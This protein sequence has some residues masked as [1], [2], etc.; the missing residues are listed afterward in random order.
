MSPGGF[1]PFVKS[2]FLGIMAK[3][4]FQGAFRCSTGVVFLNKGTCISFLLWFWCSRNSAWQ[5][6][7]EWIWWTN[8]PWV[9]VNSHIDMAPV[10]LTLWLFGL[11]CFFFLCLGAMFH[12]FSSSY[13]MQ[14][15]NDVRY[16]PTVLG[17]TA[18]P[19][20]GFI[21]V[22]FFFFFSEFHCGFVTFQKP[23]PQ[24]WPH[25][26]GLS[27]LLSLVLWEN[28]TCLL[29]LICLGAL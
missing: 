16:R 15:P 10:S 13:K 4:S 3:T 19:L 1:N 5:R 8:S 23:C 14:H 22:P 7:W 26:N 25:G 12:S 28:I 9:T 27:C 21:L 18:A 11:V 17:R 20:P 29:L 2:L 6:V 24:R